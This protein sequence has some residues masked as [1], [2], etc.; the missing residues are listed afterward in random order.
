[1]KNLLIIDGNSIINRAFYGI[2]L[3]TNKHG[4]FTNGI[5]GF[6]K[7]M[8]KS[9][10][11]VC[12]DY[13]CVAFD[14]K[15]PTFR[16]KKYAQYKAQRKGMPEEL[17]VQMPVMKEVLK[18]MNITILEKEGF[19]ADDI[20]GTVSRICDED[21][22]ACHI[23]TG[24]RDDLQLASDNT[25]VHLTITRMGQTTTSVY[26]KDEVLSE[27]GV[28]PA[29]FIDV[30]GLMG[31]TSDNIPGVKGIG[32]KTAFGYIQK[33]KS[34]ESLYE[35]LDDE[36][37]KPAARKKLE[38]GREM[39]FL[40]KEL[41]T[42]D[43]F[44]DIGAKISDFEK[45]P[46]NEEKLT[47]LFINLEFNAFL[48][49]IV[50]DSNTNSVPECNFE[51]VDVSSFV[52]LISDAPDTFIYRLYGESDIEALSFKSGENAYMV[53]PDGEFE[54]KNLALS[55][56]NIFEN[57]KT[58]KVSENIKKSMLIFNK[59]GITFDS[60]YFD[61]SIGAYVINPSKSSYDVASIATEMLEMP[62]ISE[63]DVTGTG[64]NQKCL[65]EADPDA[66]KA[67]VCQ[68]ICAIE[69]LWEYEKEKIKSDGQEFLLYE[70]EMPLVAVLADMEIQGFRVD[71]NMLESFTEK[72]GER[73]KLLEGEIYELAGEKF[74]IN[75]TKQLGVILFEKLGLK[76]IKKT[77][78]G[79]S[80]D[81]T[82]LEKL[83]GSH[84]II[85][86]ILAYRTDAK[87]KS[88]YGDGLLAVIN[89]DT[90]KIHSSFNQT[91]T[92]TGRISSTEPNLQ[93]IPMRREEGREIRKMFVAKDSDHILIDA[94]YSQIELRI[95]AHMADDE[96][97]IEAFRAGEDIHT[98]T[99]SR[100]FGV[101]KDEVT[102]LL[103]TRA[104]AVNF[105]I[106]Y[107]MGDY[108][109]SQDLKI[110][111][112]EAKE[113]I[114]SY[115]EKYANVKNYLDKTVEDAKEN[116]YVTTLFARRRYIPEISS[117]NFMTRSFGERVAMNTPIQGT[118]ADIIKIAMVK[119][120]KALKEKNLKSRLILQVH[121]E[122]IIE[123]KKTEAEEVEK[124]L[125]ECMMSAANLKTTLISETGMGESWYDAH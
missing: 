40:S 65:S 56:K 124:L 72:L 105:G 48:K 77:K 104:K 49:D 85:E 54:K 44:V 88:T 96:A 84:P 89:P 93:N 32:E 21:A 120:Y 57:E 36:I 61:I 117:S 78:T 46:Y 116:G 17:R 34:I 62:I 12:P 8:F 47:Q 83:N 39:A 50:K 22:I 43:R 69:K 95:L 35:N 3:L 55:L 101:S 63:K 103:R 42:I 51:I 92:T 25:K 113:Y 73:L 27:F 58:L 14:L 60:S 114:Q 23:L 10:D 31:D 94:D 123:A 7:I 67:F 19:E 100:V 107:G 66:L 97:M 99:A 106:V 41:C 71:K 76:V 16:H 90:G 74:N 112:K 86:K 122:L 119:I 52:N 115:F 121:D 28:T 59:Y 4:L 108:S 109:L 79:Y 15:A 24:D 91:V 111:V 81:A 110:S 68:E 29:E 70:I 98:S 64:K 1:M 11:E 20:I 5:Y 13:I 37:V 75:S 45:K 82:V 118:A 6:L 30:K 2:R 125:K 80:T 26:D 102:P 18:A 33:F 38:E 87:L 9:I 53:L